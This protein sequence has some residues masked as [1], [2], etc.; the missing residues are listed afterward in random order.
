[1]VQLVS[2]LY[3]KLGWE[4]QEDESYDLSILRF[5]L[6]YHNCFPLYLMSL[7]QYLS[8]FVFYVLI[9]VFCRQTILS[10]S[11]KHNHT[12]AVQKALSLFRENDP[13]FDRIPSERFSSLSLFFFIPLVISFLSVLWEPNIFWIAGEQCTLQPFYMEQK[14]ISGAFFKYYRSSSNDAGLFFLLFFPFLYLPHLS[15]GRTISCNVSDG[16]DK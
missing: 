9:C 12:E 5:L 2:K 6:F 10:F 13:N 14:M 3:S 4:S 15:F 8:L 16:R 7:E 11:V 1:M